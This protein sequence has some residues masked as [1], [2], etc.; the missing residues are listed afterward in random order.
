MILAGFRSYKTISY[1]TGLIT[2]DDKGSY[3]Y[4]EV[5]N[6]G[7]ADITFSPNIYP[8][9]GLAD[10][11]GIT[12]KVGTTRSIPMIIYNFQASGACTITAYRM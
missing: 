4:A 2:L 11:G 6:G 9:N 5:T 7:A 3:I 12:V 8:E 10:G 1:T